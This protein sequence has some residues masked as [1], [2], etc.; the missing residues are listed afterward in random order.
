[1]KLASFSLITAIL[2]VTVYAATYNVAAGV[3]GTLAY[4]PEYVI[5]SAGDTI[6]FSF[7]PKNHTVTQS[8]FNAPCAHLAGGVD[9]GFMPV[10][11][12]QVDL[13]AFQLKVNDSNPIWVYC[14]QT[15]HCGKGMV[16]AVN[17]GAEGSS[18]S[19][20]AFKAL[21]ISSNGTASSSSATSTY[22]PPPAQSWTTVTATVTSQTSVWLTTY[23]SYDGTPAPTY[24]PQPV[25]HKIVVG[26]D[27]KLEYGPANVSASIGDTVTFEFHPKNHTVTQSSFQHPCQPLAETSTS[28]Q[29]GFSSGFRPVAAN[30]TD[31]PTFQIRINDTAPIWGYCGQTN[32]CGSGM[33]FSINAV[34]TGPNNF[35]A[36]KEL[37]IRT[38][39]TRAGNSSGSATS[40]SGS[41]SSTGSSSAPSTSASSSDS[42]SGSNGALSI[43]VDA[44]LGAMFS[45][46]VYLAF[47]I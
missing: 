21:A 45:A 24:A 10:T 20:S 9:S 5:A 29:I 34:E 25:D 1:M 7:N 36:F 11:A 12:D 32:H 43:S 16:F 19:F 46:L 40:G 22:T 33:V 26:I 41:A 47:L 30:A 37:A 28:G 31:F 17:P 42:G 6:N 35:A 8:S 44:G 18:N 15:G 23:T 27:G 39:G 4:D 2:P 14:R 13:P 3:N 38:N